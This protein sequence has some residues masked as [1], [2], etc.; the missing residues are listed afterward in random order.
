MKRIG[1]LFILFGAISLAAGAYTLADPR[2]RPLGRSFAIWGR[3]TVEQDLM[4]S[5]SCIGL[6]VLFLSGGAI[7]IMRVRRDKKAEA[8]HRGATSLRRSP[9]AGEH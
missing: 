8:K 4:I 1:I 5:R 6:G 3:T 2:S 7:Y 9:R